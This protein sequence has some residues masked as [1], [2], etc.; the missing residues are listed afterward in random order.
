MRLG[1]IPFEDFLFGF[2]MVTVTIM[3]WEHGKRKSLL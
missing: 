1:S 2:S 3:L